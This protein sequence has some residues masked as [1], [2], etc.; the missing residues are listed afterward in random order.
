MDLQVTARVENDGHAL[1]LD[2]TSTF[3]LLEST[4]NQLHRV[5]TWYMPH[6]SRIYPKIEGEEAAKSDFELG[7]WAP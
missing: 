7:T 5:L 1:T 6:A 3:S 2:E 4:L